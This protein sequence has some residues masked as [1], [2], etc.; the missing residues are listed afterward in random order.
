MENQLTIPTDLHHSLFPD[1]HDSDEDVIESPDAPPYS[2]IFFWDEETPTAMQGSSD[3]SGEDEQDSHL[4]HTEHEDV[5]PSVS[6]L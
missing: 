6:N 1:I 4:G 2:P 3:S 5:D